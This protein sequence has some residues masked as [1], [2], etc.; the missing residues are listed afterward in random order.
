MER[1]WGADAERVRAVLAHRAAGVAVVTTRLGEERRGL[2]VTAWCSVALEPPLVLVCVEQVTTSHELIARGGIF[3]LTILAR[4]QELLAD[5]FAG[6]A[7]PVGPTFADVPHTAAVTGAPLLTGGIGWLDCRVVA[8]YPAGT[9][10]I[11]VGHVLAAG[12]AAD[13]DALSPLISVRRRYTEPS[14][15]Q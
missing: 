11:V 2:T 10:S 14:D 4:E 7:I 1:D 9:H 6:R 12:L 15:E 3:A 8:S 13:A 5:R